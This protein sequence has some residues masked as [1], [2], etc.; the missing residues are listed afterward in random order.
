MKL[1][2]L[3]AKEFSEWPSNSLGNDA[4]TQ[5]STGELNTLDTDC[6]PSFCDEDQAWRG[7]SHSFLGRAIEVADDY[8]IAVVYEAQWQ[9]ERDKQ[10]GGEWK[11]HRGGKQP[12][13]D[14]TAIEVRYR[15][16]ET[17]ECF[18]GDTHSHFWSHGGGER[19]IMQYRVISRPQA[20]EAQYRGPFLAAPIGEPANVIEYDIEFPSGVFTLEAK[21]E[22]FDG[23]L[24]WRDTII[25]CQAIIED[26]EREIQANVN[27]LDSEGLMM[28]VDSKKAMQAYDVP[29][30]DMGDWRNLKSGDIIE[31]GDSGWQSDWVGRRVTVE[32]TEP[33]SYDG[34]LPIYAVDDNDNDDWGQSYTFI[35]RP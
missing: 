7:R 4:I 19:D 9:A 22:Q 10:K 8:A 33:A 23:P 34:D 5:D 30:V 11:R 27:L 31:C 6:Y 29:A 20:E 18:A 26:C 13:A 16:G 28:Q 21:T 24:A 32:K 25:H 14:G 1:V 2:E 12:V 3:L 35:S 17:K 15:E